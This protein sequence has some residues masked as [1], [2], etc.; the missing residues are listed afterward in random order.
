MYRKIIVGYEGSNEAKDALALGELIAGTTG[1]ELVVAGVSLSHPVLRGSDPVDHEARDEL[2]EVLHRA[3]GSVDAAAQPV[4]SSSPARG[5][6][7]LAEEIDAD[8]IVVGSSRHG[9]GGQTLLGNVGLALMHGSPCAIAIAPRGY[10]ELPDRGV[11]TIV[12]GYDGTPESQLALEDGY[13]LARA[14]DV[15]LKL[16]A[17][18]EPPAIVFGKSGGANY[19]WEAV[20]ETVEERLRAQLEEARAA[21][22][23]DVDLEAKLVSG[24]PAESLAEAAKAPGSLLM[25]GSRAYGP[26]RR[27]LLGSVSR[28]LAGSAS[29]PLIVHPR[30]M[31]EEPK[32]EPTSEATATV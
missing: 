30:G 3:A 18:A 32:A 17:V 15:P 7:E 12:V 9:H 1:A 4:Q 19:G 8:L 16:V 27:V 20:K 24:S 5:L 14:A 29:A 22:P 31:H 23:D 10:A 28:A 25:L 2:R 21:A 26:L 11:S 6:H 13:E